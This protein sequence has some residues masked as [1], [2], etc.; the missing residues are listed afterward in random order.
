MF[1]RFSSCFASLFWLLFLVLVIL[2]SLIFFCWGVVFLCLMLVLF[3]SLVWALA[4]VIGEGNE[5]TAKSTADSVL[6]PFGTSPYPTLSLVVF[7][8]VSLFY[9]AGGGGL[10]QLLR[11]KFQFT[12]LQG[13]L[14]WTDFCL[15]SFLI[16]LCFLFM[17]SSSFVVNFCCSISVPLFLVVFLLL[18][19][20]VVVDFAVAFVCC[21]YC[22]CSASIGLIV[23]PHCCCSCSSRCWHLFG[24]WVCSFD[25]A[26]FAVFLLIKF[27]SSCLTSI[28]LSLFSV[29]F[30]LCLCWFLLRCLLSLF[31]FLFGVPSSHYCICSW[32]LLLFFVFMFFF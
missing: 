20:L 3:C 17:S 16:F 6:E 5:K 9:C 15:S 31:L 25:L 26:V 13:R 7:L 18:I 28:C 19:I 24:Y 2:L 22:F 1:T 27:Q 23:V 4:V 14:S 12:A 11:T 8:F 29:Y 10:L 32:S 30:F 21:S